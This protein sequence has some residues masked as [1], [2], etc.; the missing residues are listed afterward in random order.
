MF[1]GDQNSTIGKQIAAEGYALVPGVYSA[2]ECAEIAEQLERHLQACQDERAALRRGGVVYGA[3][4]LLELFPAATTLWRRPALVEL[5]RKTLGEQCGLVRG[6]FFDKP[7]AG[8]WS[9][10]WHQDLTI[11]VVDHALPSDYF[12][13][14]TRK[15]D[16][17]HVEAP[18]DLLRQMLTLRIHLDEVTPE[19]GPLQVLPGTHFARDAAPV[20]VE[21]ATI[22]CS[23]G[24]VLAMRPLLAHASGPAQ[25][26]TVRRRRILHLE[27]AG[28]KTLPDGYR[29][30]DFRPIWDYRG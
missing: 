10:P 17:P 6:L 24:D 22:L 2:A 1:P 5:L 18:D 3:R 27:F 15:A 8:N 20:A 28:P 14:R 26:G 19:N 9:L 7:P 4:N 12:R 29:W 23:A 16:V 25:A 21:P 11:A 30:Q 13:N